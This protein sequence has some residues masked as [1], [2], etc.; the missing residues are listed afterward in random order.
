[1]NK[2][3]PIFNLI[4][5][6][7]LVT[8]NLL[9]IQT[10]FFGKTPGDVS[11]LFAN[12]FTPAH[13]AFKIWSVIYVLLG[14]YIFFQSKN[15]FEKEKTVP[16]EIS[17]IGYLFI[18][19]CLLNF[20]WLIVWQSMHIAWSFLVIFI[21]WIVLIII[22][23]RLTK[24]RDTHW[25]FALPFSVYL[26]WMSVAALGNLN[27]LLMDIGFGFLGLT[28]ESWAAL[29]VVLG[30]CGGF[31]VY[32]L[33]RDFWFLLVLAWAFFGIYMKNR[34]V[35]HMLPTVAMTGM[36]VILGVAVLAAV[37]RRRT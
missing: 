2:R 13:F 18:V 12:P 30:I 14:V 21:L 16:V 34:E 1:M 35:E 25:A 9:A 5:Y 20:G 27:I 22:N 36:V 32:F 37:Q 10:P 23:Y 7:G 4:A 8:V 6:L 33:N 17:V 26:S 11:D 28:P 24:Y 19:S 29:L 15:I 31:L 3:L